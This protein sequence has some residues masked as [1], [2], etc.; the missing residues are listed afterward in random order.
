MSDALNISMGY[1]NQP[2]I[3]F[4]IY[5]SREVV[6][7]MRFAYSINFLEAGEVFFSDFMPIPKLRKEYG[8][9]GRAVI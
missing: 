3:Y 5:N 8:S 7:I 6:C 2:L 4:F 9:R 1:T